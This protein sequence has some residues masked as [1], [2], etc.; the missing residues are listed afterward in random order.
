MAFGDEPIDRFDKTEGIPDHTSWI[1][2]LVAK[3]GDLPHDRVD[4]F[5]VL[6]CHG[7]LFCSAI[8]VFE[9]EQA[10]GVVATPAVE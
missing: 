9:A 5:Q 7:C 10:R 4:S 2:Y 8:K 6:L 3:K 1:A